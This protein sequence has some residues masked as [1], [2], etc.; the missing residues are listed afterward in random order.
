[1]PAPDARRLRALARSISQGSCV[2]VLGPG[3]STDTAESSETPLTLKLACELA[4][5]L[6]ESTANSIPGDL[7]CEDI[8]HVSQ[9]LLEVEPNS[10]LLQD[11]VIEFYQGFA[12]KTTRLLRDLAELPFRLCITTTPDDFLYQ[13]LKD[14]DKTP[15]RRF[16]NFRK[17]SPMDWVEPNVKNPLVYHLYG[18]T[19]DPASLVITENDLIDFLV[20]VVQRER[21]LP[22]EIT[23]T[24]M[25]STCLFI[26][27]GF[28]NWYLRVLLRS[29]GLRGHGEMSLALEEPDF[30]EHSKQHQTTVYFSSSKTIQFRQDSLAEFVTTLREAYKQLADIETPILAL[31]PSG[32]PK[33]FLSYASEDRELVEVLSSKLQ[34]SG[35]AVWQDKQ[36]LRV[37]DNW[38]CTL[39]QVISKQ[40][41][42]V[43]VVQTPEMMKQNEGVFYEEVK[44]ALAREA[45]MKAGLRFILPVRTGK[46]AGMQQLSHLHYI[47][48]DADEGVEALTGAI[49]EDWKSRTVAARAMEASAV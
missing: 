37:G 28:K 43:V 1:M 32:A 29:L 3:A 6:R 18:Y 46:V 44:Q 42:Y 2:L 7:D 36:N 21:S 5:T 10:T 11:Q 8:R 27:L 35:I 14:A 47:S 9:V 45:R 20:S 19:S 30:F 16:Y 23:N 25:R 24:L 17:P 41:N 22:V 4:D 39:T 34:A 26:D 13:A 38:A 48:I 33:A 12:G 40:V 15:V 49:W 31:P